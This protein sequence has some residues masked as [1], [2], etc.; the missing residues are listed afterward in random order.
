MSLLVAIEGGDGAGKATAAAKLVERAQRAGYSATVLA[1]PRYGDTVGGHVIGEF[2]AGKLPRALTPRAAAVLYA[3]DRLESAAH[4]AALA[5]AHDLV[6]LDRYIASNI[7]YQAAKVPPEDAPA[8]IEWIAQLETGQFALPLPALNVYLDTPL[9]VARDLILRKRQRSYTDRSY[10]E[11]EADLALQAGVRR[12]YVAMAAQS[13]LGHW[14][15]VHTVEGGTMR[16]PDAIADEIAAEVMRL[17][18]PR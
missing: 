10:D 15:T 18:P 2:L 4:L 17:L 5:G 13:V 6:V 7:A 16:T 14:Q 8:L 11:H 12:C 1:F 9:E 3:L